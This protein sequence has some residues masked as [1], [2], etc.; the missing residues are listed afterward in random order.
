MPLGGRRLLPTH[1]PCPPPFLCQFRV[2]SLLWLGLCLQFRLRL[3]SASSR[4]RCS[5]TRCLLQRPRR[6]HTRPRQIPR[7]PQLLRELLLPNH[8]RRLLNHPLGRLRPGLLPRRSSLPSRSLLTH[9]LL[10]L[11]KPPNGAHQMD[12]GDIDATFPENFCDPV[13]VQSMPMSFQDLCF[14]SSQGVIFG[15]LR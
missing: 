6:R 3:G 15:C 8:S 1:P 13:D 9:P 5:S 2:P 4:F 14:I 12:F 10:F 7:N 11:N